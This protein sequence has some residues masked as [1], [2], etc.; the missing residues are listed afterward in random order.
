MATKSANVFV[1]IEPDLK[2]QAESILG[3]LGIPVSNAIQMYYKQII[4]HQGLPF[5]VKLPKER[6]LIL[7]EL[8]QDELEAEIQK[9]IDDMNTGRV[10]SA[11]KVF[12]DLRKKYN[13]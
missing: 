3:E 5:D 1:R 13:L 4:L 6:P 9:G 11:D 12:S 2:E 10:E 7:E 8:T